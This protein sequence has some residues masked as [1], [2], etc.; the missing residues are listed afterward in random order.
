MYPCERTVFPSPS[1]LSLQLFYLGFW[2]NIWSLKADCKSGETHKPCPHHA[3][4]P[5]LVLLIIH[6]TLMKH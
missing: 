2:L 5:G 3:W 6:L 1:P 4:S